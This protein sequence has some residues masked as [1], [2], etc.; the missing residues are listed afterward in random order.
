MTLRSLI[1]IPDSCRFSGCQTVAHEISLPFCPGH[2][3]DIVALVV[4]AE[5]GLVM[6]A[7]Y[8]GETHS[9]NCANY[10]NILLRPLH[11]GPWIGLDCALDENSSTLEYG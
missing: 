3:T 7:S 4:S 5:L 10:M 11:F 9:L 6:S 1:F 8:Q 2:E